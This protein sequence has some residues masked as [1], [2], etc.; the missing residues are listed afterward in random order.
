MR[1][2]QELDRQQ[3]ANRPAPILKTVEEL[4]RAWKPYK[5]KLSDTG[6]ERDTA[7][8]VHRAFSWLEQ[9]EQRK[10]TDDHRL[11]LLWISFNTLYGTW[12][13][14][15]QAPVSDSTSWNKFLKKILKLDQ[16]QLLSEVL[17][18]HRR[19]VMALLQDEYLSRYF[20]Q[21]PTPKRAG[22]SRKAMHEAKTWYLQKKW[23]MILNR[24]MER[25][26]LARCQLVRGASTYGS[27][28][29]RD[30]LRRCTKMLAQLQPGFLSILIT[31]GAHENWGLMC[32]PP[33]NQEPKPS[34]ENSQP[35]EE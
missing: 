32:Y 33:L 5:E 3:E 6:F 11:I 24:V 35:L 17:T 31:H 22:Q 16:D 7:I 8:R 1:E 2:N 9:I 26:Y 4:R 23:G 34:S 15:E 20:W 30:A 21:D 10:T 19:L 13:P 29:N 25:I 28:L 12:D 27:Q 14:K 18:Q